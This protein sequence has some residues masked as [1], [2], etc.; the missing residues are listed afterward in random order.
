MRIEKLKIFTSQPEKQLRFYR[1]VLE[2][3]IRISSKDSFE[4][5]IGFS[6]LK[7]QKKKNVR[8]YHIAFHIPALQELQALAWLEKKVDILKDGKNEIVDFSSWKAKSVYFYDADKNILEFISRKELFPSKNGIFGVKSLLGISEI[9]LAT[10]NVQKKFSFLNEHF[11]LKK[12]TGDYETFCATGDDEGLFIIVNK[13]KKTWFPSSDEAF[14]SEFEIGIK[15][16]E[17]S[18]KLT[19]KND[20][21]EIL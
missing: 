9:G 14:A 3:D 13:N 12:F 1:D 20:R 19:F 18:G 2:L 15:T 6:V 11:S 7:V 16:G 4:V 8:P 5:K 17:V 21:L 10:D